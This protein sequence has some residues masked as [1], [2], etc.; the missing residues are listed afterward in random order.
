MQKQ[1]KKF[2][3]YRC[4]SDKCDGEYAINPDVTDEPRCPYCCGQ[5]FTHLSDKEV[6]L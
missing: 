4:A 3:F 5:Y 1:F 2:S 6:A